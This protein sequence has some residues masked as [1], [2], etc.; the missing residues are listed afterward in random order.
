MSLSW[1]PGKECGARTWDKWTPAFYS[2]PLFFASS[3]L[4]LVDNEMTVVSSLWSR[5]VTSYT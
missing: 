4:H 5:F 3:W 1:L 2:H